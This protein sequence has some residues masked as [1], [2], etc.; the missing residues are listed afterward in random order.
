MNTRE[1]FQLAV[2]ARNVKVRITSDELYPYFI[3]VKRFGT[4]YRFPQRVW[5]NY[6][7]TQTAFEKAWEALNAEIK[8]YE[9][10]DDG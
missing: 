4:V 3:K 7:K 8:K 1:R 5:R 10:H 9:L 6:A 2:A